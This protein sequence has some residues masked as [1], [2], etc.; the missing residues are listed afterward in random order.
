MYQPSQCHIIAPP[1]SGGPV[2][3]C[4]AFV[5]YT[6]TYNYPERPLYEVAT[7]DASCPSGQR[8]V[9]WDGRVV[10]FTDK[11]WDYFTKPVALPKF[12]TYGGNNVEVSQ[13][14]RSPGTPIPLDCLVRI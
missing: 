10:R 3:Y 11:V 14:M 8:L 12:V 9:A 1:S 13:E 6:V 5:Q 4:E 2:Y 7:P